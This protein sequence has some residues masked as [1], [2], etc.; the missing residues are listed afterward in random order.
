M[1]IRFRLWLRSF[2]ISETTEEEGQFIRRVQPAL[3][4]ARSRAKPCRPSFKPRL[5]SL[6]DRLV[7]S[8]PVTPTPAGAVGNEPPALVAQMTP[9][10]PASVTLENYVSYV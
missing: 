5:E 4:T 1:L 2:I 10:N 8:A 6:E 7:P 9:L 3:V